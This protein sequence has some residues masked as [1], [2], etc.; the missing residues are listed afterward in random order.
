MWRNPWLKALVHAAC[1]APFVYLAWRLYQS[2]HG[3]DPLVNRVEYVS[4]YTGGWTLKLLIATLAITP[5]RKL[6]RL[7]QMIQFRRMLGLWTFFYGF[8]HGLH[9]FWFD[10]QWDWQ[11]LGEDLTKRR[12]FIAGAFTLLTMIPLAITSTNGSIRRL[13]GKKWQRL[14]RLIYITAVAGMI[15]YIWQWK[16]VTLNQM[17]YP[18]ILVV[19]LSSRV[20]FSLK[21][22]W[23]RSRRRREAAASLVSSS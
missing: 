20:V 1:I 17:W 15:H 19:L 21:K 5:L 14:H 12:F 10:A 22:Q 18:G 3:I 13:G 7:G 16:A 8:V 2:A 11:V 4:R 6:P 9:Y 23:E